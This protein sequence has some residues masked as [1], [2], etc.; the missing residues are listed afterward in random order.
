METPAP[1]YQHHDWKYRDLGIRNR[2]TEPCY[3]YEQIGML[4]KKIGVRQDPGNL[5][6]AQ[7][8]PISF[9]DVV[10]G[11]STVKIN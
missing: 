11:A 8:S 1:G 6:C 7:T 4:T 10:K 9:P 2:T 3:L 5:A